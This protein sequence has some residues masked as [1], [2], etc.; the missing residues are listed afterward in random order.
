MGVRGYVVV[1]RKMGIEEIL[2]AK[3]GLFW[4][5]QNSEGLPY[6]LYERWIG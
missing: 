6:R 4:V 5:C 1:V 3:K 2:E